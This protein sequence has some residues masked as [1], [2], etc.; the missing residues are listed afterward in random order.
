MKL[1]GNFTETYT[2]LRREFSRL[3]SLYNIGRKAVIFMA[4]GINGYAP[5][6]N[7]QGQMPMMQQNFGNA[8]QMQQMQPAQPSTNKWFVVSAEDAMSR[9]AQ[10][11]SVMIYLLQDESTLYEVYTDGQGKKG[12]RVRTLSDAQPEKPVEYATKSELEEL[13]KM[14]EGMKGGTES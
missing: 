2:E 13:K 5:Q 10:P 11:N 3:F 8:A 7:F 9:Y 4:W 12:I 1:F 14:I 6:P